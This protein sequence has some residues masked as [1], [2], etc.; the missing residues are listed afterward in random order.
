MLAVL[1]SELAE[2]A[3]RYAFLLGLR[4]VEE[5]LANQEKA[6]TQV[7]G[8]HNSPNTVGVLRAC[9]GNSTRPSDNEKTKQIG[10]KDT[11]AQKLG[12]FSKPDSGQ[13]AASSGFAG[14]QSS[15]PLAAAP[16]QRAHQSAPTAR[17]SIVSSPTL[18]RRASAVGEFVAAVTLGIEKHEARDATQEKLAA[19][20]STVEVVQYVEEQAEINSHL[21]LTAGY[22]ALSVIALCASKTGGGEDAAMRL[23]RSFPALGA[24]VDAESTAADT[25]FA[26]LPLVVL[27]RGGVAT[28]A[29]VLGDWLCWRGEH[30]VGVDSG[31]LVMQ[32]AGFARAAMTL[33]YVFAQF[34]SLCACECGLVVASALPQATN[35]TA[36]AEIPGNG[37]ALFNVSGAD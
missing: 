27:A 34:G 23:A 30:W 13:P 35:A 14:P 10:E 22:L 33:A 28:L 36:L 16:A 8:V 26:Q 32:R 1:G 17:N 37:T 4:A 5:R 24:N 2:C 31:R 20:K 18:N 12:G 6:P 21:T 15:P 7:I 9:E 29:A 19:A 3:S 25:D 11:A